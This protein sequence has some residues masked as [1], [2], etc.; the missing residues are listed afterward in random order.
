MGRA[1]SP[2]P[3]GWPDDTAALVAGA[4]LFG[5]GLALMAWDPPAARL[6]ERPL[7]TRRPR[8]GAEAAGQARDVVARLMPASL[9]G[10]IGRTLAIAGAGL[11]LVRLL[12]RA[13]D[14]DALR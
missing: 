1:P 9:T 3:Q 13:A 5:A 6:P 12:D 11:V 8:R 10:G 7:P 4:L 14:D 2:S